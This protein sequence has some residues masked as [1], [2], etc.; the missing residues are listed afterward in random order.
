MKLKR[1][2]SNSFK[3]K[4]SPWQKNTESLCHH[5]E[6]EFILYYKKT[7]FT[8][9]RLYFTFDGDSS[10]LAKKYGLAKQYHKLTHEEKISIPKWF[11]GFSIKILS[12]D[13]L[14]LQVRF[15]YYSKLSILFCV[16]EYDR[17]PSSK[18][19]IQR[20]KEYLNI[21]SKKPAQ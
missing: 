16:N 13:Y 2:Y 20:F 10:Y 14:F 18:S 3:W 8:I 7:S 6:Y 21:K 11:S 12:K 9:L 19:F 17:W 1:R 4:D 15:P 5:I